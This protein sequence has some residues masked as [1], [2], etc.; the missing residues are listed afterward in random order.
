[1]IP[2]E[3]SSLPSVGLDVGLDV[4]SSV[5][6]DVSGDEVGRVALVGSAD[7]L[8]V[9]LPLVGPVVVAV[10]SEPVDAS[11]SSPPPPPGL[12]Q[13]VTTRPRQSDAARMS[14]YYRIAVAA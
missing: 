6:I 5:V 7:V 10:S 11:V 4:G 2:P 8:G 3:L 13:A 12:K 14:A 9:V 1:M